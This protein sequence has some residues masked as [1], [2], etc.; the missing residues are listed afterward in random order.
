MY[1]T[2][3][4]NYTDKNVTTTY[5]IQDSIYN[6]M[7]TANNNKYKLY[8]ETGIVEYKITWYINDILIQFLT[9]EKFIDTK[10]EYFS[11]TYVYTIKDETNIEEDSRILFSKFVKY[12][13]K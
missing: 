10:Y 12:V 11:D 8:Y 2:K 4:T 1:R 5:Y 7:V 6:G 3:F 13:K 9:G